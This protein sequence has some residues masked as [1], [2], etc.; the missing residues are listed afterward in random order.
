MSMQASDPST[1]AGTVSESE[2]QH[3]IGRR[4][5]PLIR[6]AG[7]LLDQPVPIE[8]MTRPMVGRFFAEAT[9]LEELLDRYGARSNRRWHRFRS[10]TAACKSF[11]EV[12]YELLHLRDALPTYRLLPIDQDFQQ[13]TLQTLGYVA[14]VLVDVSARLVAAAKELSLPV[15][16]NRLPVG[17]MGEQLPPGRLGQDREARAIEAVSEAV[18]RLATSFLNLGADNVWIQAAGAASTQEYQGLMGDPISEE[19]LRIVQHRFHNLQSVYDTYIA[20]TNT[21]R[22]DTD[23]RVLRGHISVVFHLL[24]TGTALAH[25]HERHVAAQASGG[26]G[27]DEVFVDPA[28]LLDALIRYS[29]AFAGRFIA[30]PRELCQVKLR[31]YTQVGCVSV[32]V[33]RYRGFHVRPSTLVAKI[34]LHY[35]SDVRMLLDDEE[36]D[37]STPIEIFRAN[38]KINAWKRRWLC[39]QVAR[40]P[41]FRNGADDVRMAAREALAHLIESRLVVAYENPIRWPE[42]L[43]TAEGTVMERVIV[44]LTRLQATGKIDIETDMSITFV[45][46][47]RVLA[48][49]ELLARHGYGEDSLGN[50]VPLPGALAYLR[51]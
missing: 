49:L 42:D 29:L 51:R 44:E 22:T 33:P 19:H 17:G 47:R 48:D 20:A 31:Q 3:L 34:V 41:L 46:D 28:R 2:F 38:E 26:S 13:A 30:A 32:P 14:E 10:L 27:A 25:Y 18:T 50:N 6:V 45:G 35:G 40:L 5:R 37:A 9:Q 15:A 1:S 16:A 7:Y 24:K 43:V 11:G 36:Y 39:T 21:A 8:A 23:L 12:G 4:A